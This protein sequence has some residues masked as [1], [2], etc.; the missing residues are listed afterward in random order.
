[1]KWRQIA[2]QAALNA[3]FGCA[4]FPGFHGFLRHL[5]EAEKVGVCLARAAAE[6]AELAAHKTN[7]GE[8]DVAID[9]VGHEVADEFAAQSVGR[10]QQSEKVVAVGICQQ[11]ALL[12]GKA[13]AVL[14]LERG[15]E[16]GTD[17]AHSTGIRRQAIPARESSRVRI[18]PRFAGDV[19]RTCSFFFLVLFPSA[20]LPVNERDRS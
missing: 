17:R 11:Q 1:M 20:I 5:L 8:I 13:A 2:R 3:D 16:R 15:F 9:D 12:A 18:V 4:E 19:L 14:A 6:G 10:D 7:V